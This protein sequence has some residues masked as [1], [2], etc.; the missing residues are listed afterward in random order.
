MNH[1]VVVVISAMF[2]LPTFDFVWLAK[3][4]VISIKLFQLPI[5]LTCT[6]DFTKLCQSLIIP[7]E[8]DV[9]FLGPF[10]N[11]LPAEKIEFS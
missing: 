7:T 1:D 10:C 3:S 8:I 5:T 9:S 4:E 11:T 6:Q 2:I